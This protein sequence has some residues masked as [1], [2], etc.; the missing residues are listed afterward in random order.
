MDRKPEGF[1]SLQTLC[2]VILTAALLF[3]LHDLHKT[4]VHVQSAVDNAATT[5]SSLQQTSKEL[6]TDLHNTS[7]NAN[8]ILLQIGIASDEVRRASYEQRAYWRKTAKQTDATV[9]SL[10][11]LIEHTDSELNGSVFP[12][13][14]SALYD[15]GT[16]VS[17]AAS[18][19]A[20]SLRTGNTALV[21]ADEAIRR[22]TPSLAD[23]S[24]N[25]A[26]TSAHLAATTADIQG[27]VHKATR[28]ATLT[29][30]IFEH[31]LGILGNLGSF[32][33]GLIK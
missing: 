17:T 22:I 11:H 24:K 29:E 18:A 31:T 32:V 33:G 7:Q 20:T 1:L 30:E 4:L 9:A 6:R 12:A 19:A 23:S 5:L 25:L 3:I 28:P 26:D 10:H 15:I 2:I 27:A 14:E 13:T 8:A 16:N 21:D